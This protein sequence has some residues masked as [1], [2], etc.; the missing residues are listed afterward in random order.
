MNMP[1]LANAYALLSESNSKH[2]AQSMQVIHQQVRA[3]H[4]EQAHGTPIGQN[5]SY[6]CHHQQIASCQANA[7]SVSTGFL[8]CWLA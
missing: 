3:L 6:T 1:I 4:A 2:V 7:I 8:G 5:R